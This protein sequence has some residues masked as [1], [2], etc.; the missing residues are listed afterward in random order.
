MSHGEKKNNFPRSS[1]SIRGDGGGTYAV[2]VVHIVDLVDPETF[3]LV[4]LLLL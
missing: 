1:Y 2:L 4:Q 3:P